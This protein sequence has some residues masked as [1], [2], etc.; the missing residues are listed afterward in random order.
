MS[1]EV[2]ISFIQMSNIESMIS[3][4]LE[5][6]KEFYFEML[7]MMLIIIMKIIVIVIITKIM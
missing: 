4:S 7:M 5:I 2:V 1:T 6:M 3:N